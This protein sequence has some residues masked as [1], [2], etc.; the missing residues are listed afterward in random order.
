MSPAERK[1]KGNILLA[2]AE[3]LIAG[4]EAGHVEVFTQ[5]DNPFDEQ[6]LPDQHRAWLRGFWVGRSLDEQQVTMH[7]RPSVR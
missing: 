2:M 1:A 3:A 4:R 7:V 5:A 6:Q